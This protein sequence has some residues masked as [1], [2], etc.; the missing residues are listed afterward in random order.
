LAQENPAGAKLDLEA[1]DGPPARRISARNIEGPSGLRVAVG[2]NDRPFRYH[3]GP[4][5]A[6]LNA[7]VIPE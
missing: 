5:P 6:S 1:L 3:P 7:F 2:R 4:L